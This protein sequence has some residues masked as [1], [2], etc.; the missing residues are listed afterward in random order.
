MQLTYSSKINCFKHLEL[1]GG[2]INLTIISI[3]VKNMNQRHRYHPEKIGVN[4]KA[5]F[6][7]D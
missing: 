5:L 7:A 6:V 2:N 3:G 1:L 4:K